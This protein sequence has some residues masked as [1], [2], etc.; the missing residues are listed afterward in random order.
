[1]PSFSKASEAKLQTC[2]K[3]LQIVFREVIK[4]ID[5]TVIEGYRGKEAQNAAVKAGNSMLPYVLTL[6]GTI[7][8]SLLTRS[9]LRRIRFNGTWKILR[10]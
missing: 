9:M 1:M 6:R 2:H 3:D 7:T 4:H 10:F 8:S 5:C